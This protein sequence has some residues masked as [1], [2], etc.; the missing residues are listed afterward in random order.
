MVVRSVLNPPN[1]LF[2]EYYPLMSED[3]FPPSQ[4]AIEEEDSW[5]VRMVSDNQVIQTM[6]E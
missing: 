1:L 2:R 4:V 6:S 5:S 3:K